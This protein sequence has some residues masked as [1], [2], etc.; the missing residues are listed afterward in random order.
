L[1]PGTTVPAGGVQV[2]V[3]GVFL[4]APTLLQGNTFSMTDRADITAGFPTFTTTGAGRGNVIDT[5]VFADGVHTIGWLVTDTL[6]RADGVGSR[7]FKTANSSLLAG[8]DADARP[9]QPAFAGSTTAFAQL[10]EPLARVRAPRSTLPVSF[11]VGMT[12]TPVF[13]RA[14]S[15]LNR[16]EVRIREMERV[17]VNVG[18]AEKGATYAAYRVVNGQLVLLPVGASFDTAKG[19]FYWLPAP[20]FIG[21]YDF[22][23][24]KQ[25]AGRDVAQTSVRITVGPSTAVLRAGLFR[26]HES[27]ATGTPESR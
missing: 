6:S 13:R 8:V 14:A 9:A 3:D 26:A 10:G 20:G 25:A 4:A 16:S 12:P 11:G 2:A 5:T 23:F 21:D 22:V 27:T 19:V 17:V 15:G 24:V 7:F 18:R 1:S